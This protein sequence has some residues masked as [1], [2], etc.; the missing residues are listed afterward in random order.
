MKKRTNKKVH[1][2]PVLYEADPEG[3]FMVFAPTLPGCHTQGETLEEAEHNI[4]EAIEL[5]LEC[6]VAEKVSI[7]EASKSFYGTVDVWTPLSA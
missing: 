3:G 6:I 5:Y 4:A 7:P 2:Y 1:S